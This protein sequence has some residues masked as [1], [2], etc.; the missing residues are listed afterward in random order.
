MYVQSLRALCVHTPELCCFNKSDW[1]CPNFSAQP[2]ISTHHFLYIDNFIYWR[3][4]HTIHTLL[5]QY[6]WICEN[7]PTVHHYWP[8]AG[9]VG[10]GSVFVTWL[11][12]GCD[13]AIQRHR[14]QYEQ[15]CASRWRLLRHGFYTNQI[16]D[17]WLAKAT[18]RQ[19]N[20]TKHCSFILLMLC[21]KSRNRTLVTA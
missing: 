10:Q 14:T 1:V 3:S 17:F 12:Q 15:Q 19:Q 16:T 5:A 18:F 6:L 21:V 8:T 13:T 11:H 9:E 2:C 7:S 4:F 20:T